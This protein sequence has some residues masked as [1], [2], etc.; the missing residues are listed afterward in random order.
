MKF[1]SS[2]EPGPQDLWNVYD[3]NERA[4]VGNLF[5]CREWDCCMV[6]YDIKC[7][8]FGYCD[9]GIQNWAEFNAF[10]KETFP[11]LECLMV[12]QSC[13][14][15]GMNED[16]MDFFYDPWIQSIWIEDYQTKYLG[17]PERTITDNNSNNNNKNILRQRVF[18][19]KTFCECNTE[20]YE[21]RCISFKLSTM[22][23]QLSSYIESQE[24]P[25]FLYLTQNDV[26]PAP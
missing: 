3:D 7:V 26:M 19:S 14:V 13:S 23:F 5:I 20:V 4:Y 18:N 11:S 15:S 8:M 17:L 10:L 22:I 1:I 2:I 25:S 16:F 24:D 9:R 21:C 6:Y 12:T